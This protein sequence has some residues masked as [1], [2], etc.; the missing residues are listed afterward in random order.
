M[1]K[2]EQKIAEKI[3]KREKTSLIVRIL[4]WIGA[5]TM[6]I[7]I[8]VITVGIVFYSN[9]YSI[10]KDFQIIQTG[11]LT[12]KSNIRSA[13]LK[14][15]GLNENTTPEVITSLEEGNYEILV[16][17]QNYYPYEFSVT[18]DPGLAY[19]VYANLFYTP[20]YIENTTIQKNIT[21]LYLT[22]YNTTKAIG[23]S[24]DDDE[25]TIYKCKLKD[26][27]WSSPSCEDLGGIEKIFSTNDFEIV[28]DDSFNYI[29]S[30][31][32][33]YMLIKANY[34]EDLD[35]EHS[36]ASSIATEN[37]SGEDNKYSIG[38]FIIDLES[39]DIEVLSLK[40]FLP[41]DDFIM[42]ATNDNNIIYKRKEDLISYDVADDSNTILVGNWNDN[43]GNYHLSNSRLYVTEKEGIFE[44]RWDGKKS[45]EK[46]KNEQV[47][48]DLYT[49]GEYI[50]DTSKIEWFQFF[51]KNDYF[52]CKID[53]DYYIFHLKDKT[54]VRLNNDE[55]NDD[56]EIISVSYDQ[57][58]LLIRS[59]GTYYV[60][61]LYIEDW[62]YLTEYKYYKIWDCEDENLCSFSWADDS[63]VLF[64]W[65]KTEDSENG[66]YLWYSDLWGI[67]QQLLA[68]E[69]DSSL[70]SVRDAS[71]LYVLMYTNADDKDLV[72]LAIR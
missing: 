35:S 51:D 26:D 39:N 68:D 18:I 41:D 2:K 4:S 46:L 1:T 38:Y 58:K 8:V 62:D 6:P 49:E 63:S 10:T 54:F 34:I 13:D 7:I 24:N 37:G 16:E 65:M 69:I 43:T 15:N 71:Q 67:N 12:V 28:I 31:S 66:G 17:K 36:D 64:V 27:F 47:F 52:F 5:I 45:E 53:N 56:L 21:K 60:L 50:L 59:G 70:T 3:I 72:E 9:G 29:L 22:E 14:I 20:Q 19:T 48:H 55:I 33:R 30:P 32:L 25:I 57:N 11:V 61:W 42:W 44:K 23:I 40:S